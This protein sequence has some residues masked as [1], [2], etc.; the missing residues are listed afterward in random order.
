MNKRLKGT[1]IGIVPGAL[2]GVLALY[3]FLV[4]NYAG[5]QGK[6]GNINEYLSPVVGV[7]AVIVAMIGAAIGAAGGGRKKR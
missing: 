6:M 3:L 1:L 2:L 4:P 5:Y 7:L